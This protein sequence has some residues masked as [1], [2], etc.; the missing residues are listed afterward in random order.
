MYDQQRHL[1]QMESYV[2]KRE[3]DKQNQLMRHRQ[4]MKVY[5][6]ISK[7]HESQS[8]QAAE[9]LNKIQNHHEKEARQEAIKM[10]QDKVRKQKEMA[11]RDGVKNQLEEKRQQ[12]DIMLE[13]KKR[14][15]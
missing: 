11:W 3:R 13:Q 1:Q 14:E 6:E 7:I 12:Q 9:L 10:S 2:E 8:K 5:D 4:N 15:R